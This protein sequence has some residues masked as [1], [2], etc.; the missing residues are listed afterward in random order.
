[1]DGAAI[2]RAGRRQSQPRAVFSGLRYLL[3]YGSTCTSA[4]AMPRSPATV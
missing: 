1:M 2:R 4:R 3:R